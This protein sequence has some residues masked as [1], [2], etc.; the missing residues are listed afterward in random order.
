VYFLPRKLTLEQEDLLD[1]QEDEVDAVI[2]EA[3]KAWEERKRGLN[4]QLEEVRRGVGE[5][6]R[7][8]A[9]E[10]AGVEKRSEKRRGSASPH[11]G[12]GD[13]AASDRRSRLESPKDTA[14]QVD[15]R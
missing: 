1:D 9:E 8:D 6:K 2:D 12:A 14:M 4:E 3:E 13:A 7:R 15:S 10:G 5:I 11:R